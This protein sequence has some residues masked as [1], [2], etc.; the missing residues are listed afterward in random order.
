[1]VL[2]ECSHEDLVP[3]NLLKGIGVFDPWLGLGKETQKRGNPR[4]Q[5]VMGKFLCTVKRQKS[6]GAGWGA[7]RERAGF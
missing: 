3:R 6:A 4:V 1:M 2:A 7:G 5:G